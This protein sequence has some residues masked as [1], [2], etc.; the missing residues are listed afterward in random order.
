MPDA[1]LHVH[2]LGP[3][4]VHDATGRDLTPSGQLQRRLLALLTLHRGRTV[5]ADTA[6]EALWPDDLPHDPS[7]ALQ[8]HVARLR[9]LLPDGVVQS[10]GS[11]YRLDPAC[12]AVDAD[13]RA[14]LVA[15]DAAEV[16]AELRTI[17]TTWTGPAYADLDDVDD[18]LAE[19]DRLDELR[20]RA[21]E[22][23]AESRLAAGDL[24][25]LVPDLTALV[26]AAPLRERPRALLMSALSALG[27]NV[28]ALRAYD[29]FRRLLSDELGIEPSPALTAQHAELLAGSERGTPRLQARLPTPT[30]PLVGRDDLLGRIVEQVEAERLVTLVGPGGVGKTRLLV[31]LGRR[32]VGERPDRAVVWCELAPADATSAGDVVAAALGIDGRP[33][34]PIV[35]RVIDVVGDDDLVLLLDNCEHVLHAAAE[36]VDIVLTRCPNTRVAVTSR[37][38]LRLPGE[39][40]CPVPP[41]PSDDARSPAVELFVQRAASVSPG[42]GADDPRR[43]DIV[44]IVHRLDGLPLAIELAA[45]RLHTL[46]LAEVA[47]GLDRRFELLATGYRGT[48]RHASLAAAVSWSFDS[49]DADLQR[50]FSALSVFA[51][52]FTVRDVAAVCG[53]EPAAATTLL[54]ELVERSLLHRAT[55]GRYAMLETLRAYAAEQLRASDAA[56]AGGERHARWMVE[57][58]QDADRA[59]SVP[60]RPVLQEVDD[61]IPELRTALGWLLDHDLVDHAGRLVAALVNYGFLRLRPDVLGWAE[62]VLARSH[63]RATPMAPALLAA[64]SYVAWMG[65]DIDGAAN[66]VEQALAA[67]HATEGAAPVARVRT[68]R[69]NVALFAGRLEEAAEWYAKGITAAADDP[70]ERLFARATLLLAWG[71]AAN[72]EAP[73]LAEEILTELGTPLTPHAAYTWYCA[74]E[75]DLAFDVDRARE[76]LATAIELAE[77]THAPFVQGIAGASK[78]SI[79]ARVGDPERAMAEYRWPIDHWRRSGMWSTQWTA[80]RAVAGLLERIGRHHDAAVLEGAVRSTQVG[81]RIFGADAAALDALGARLRAALGD[82]TYEAARAAGARLDG[83]AAVEHALRTLRPGT[84]VTG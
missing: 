10:V 7:A 42:F 29:D 78:A 45:A 19:S 27:R 22:L 81:H 26:T 4:R 8:N 41:L 18:A 72:P 13:R 66:L 57:W 71:Y 73:A 59:L 6:I 74:G 39:H 58:V 55:G 44:D 20:L 5:S 12:V 43:A 69:G 83:T 9:R 28:E 63:D 24:D 60:G 54:A 2:V 75:A 56:D 33:G 47:A 37:E 1:L 65:G 80:L 64:S 62:L 34:V 21:R 79:E 36:L 46:E 35:Q 3:V 31:E 76:R 84:V 40:L 17:L 70:A 51:R 30:T 15:G 82:A 50:C 52:P 25:G 67:E 61:A 49:L 14:E 48:A 77:A 68:I 32:L 53:L 11:G 23:V 38:R 16:A